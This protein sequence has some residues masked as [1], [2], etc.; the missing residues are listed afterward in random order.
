[1]K[2]MTNANQGRPHERIEG[3]T[4]RDL[5]NWLHARVQMDIV[6]GFNPDLNLEDVQAE[7]VEGD[8]PRFPLPQCT[9]IQLRTV[10]GGRYSE[11]LW[12]RLMAAP[13]GAV[14]VIFPS[15]Q[16]PLSDLGKYVISLL[17]EAARR[18]VVQATGK[19][20]QHPTKADDRHARRGPRS[21]PPEEKKRIVELWLAK[22][23]K[24]TQEAFCQAHGIGT[25]TLRGWV[26]EL[27][28]N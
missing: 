15:S 17:E 8:D 9:D 19:A 24:S 3:T 14:D 21:T 16:D 18:G 13:G 4:V 22:K 20:E 25:S 2:P 12:I 1:M 26:R 7:S 27:A 10:V 28:P 6:C 11:S 23:G 5:A